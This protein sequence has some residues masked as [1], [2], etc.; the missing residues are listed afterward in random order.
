MELLLDTHAFLWALGDPEKLS[1]VARAAIEDPENGIFV[2]A[3]VA[4]EIGIKY[5]LGKLS[6]PME[7]TIYVPACIGSFG[8]KS[9]PISQE[10]T[11]AVCGLPNH[12][13]DP[14]D[15]IMIAQA[16]VEGFTFVT[17]D[18]ESLKYPVK[19]LKAS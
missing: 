9:L 16:Q 6:L 3:A 7:P 2:S 13:N 18:S 11:L 5:A 19:L 1:P 14:F 8:F 4:W 15:R 12:H 17:S 10:H